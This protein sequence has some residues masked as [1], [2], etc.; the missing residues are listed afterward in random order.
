MYVYN[1]MLCA[2]GKHEGLK[3]YKKISNDVLQP[4][5]NPKQLLKSLRT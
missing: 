3:Y 5:L 1:L 2:L 4:P